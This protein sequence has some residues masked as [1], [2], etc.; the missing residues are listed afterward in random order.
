M[1]LDPAQLRDA[2]AAAL[3]YSFVPASDREAL[4]ARCRGRGEE[5]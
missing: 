3:E 5:A 4:L 1:G 2:Q